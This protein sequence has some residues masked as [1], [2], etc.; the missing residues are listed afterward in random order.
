[1]IG[2]WSSTTTQVVRARSGRPPEG[3]M[4]MLSS[5]RGLSEITTRAR[6]PSPFSGMPLHRNGGRDPGRAV[7]EKLDHRGAEYRRSHLAAFVRHTQRLHHVVMGRPIGPREGVCES[8]T[9]ELR[10]TLS[11]PPGCSA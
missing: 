8:L 2:G 9:V 11:A 4:E 10:M 6:R 3:F 1:M 7:L 5:V